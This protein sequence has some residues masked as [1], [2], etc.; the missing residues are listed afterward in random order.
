MYEPGNWIGRI[1]PKPLLMVVAR[2]DTVTPTDLQLAAFERAVE[3]KR[4]KIVPGGHFDAYI[5]Q[6]EPTSSAALDWFSQHL[7]GQ[8]A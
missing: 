1:G 5:A 3:P 4:L 6:F 7:Q 2:D 8:T